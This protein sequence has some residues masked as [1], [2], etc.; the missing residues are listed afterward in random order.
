MNRTNIVVLGNKLISDTG[1]SSLRV[2]QTNN[3][4]ENAIEGENL[5]NAHAQCH[6]REDANS[7]SFKRFL[8]SAA[9]DLPY[10]KC[11]CATALK[12]ANTVF[13]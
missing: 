11:K 10:L 7:E 6:M 5:H 8:K 4:P 9:A 13:R 1:R 12:Q 3:R 2:W